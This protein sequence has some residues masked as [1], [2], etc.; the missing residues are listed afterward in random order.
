VKQAIAIVI[1]LSLFLQCTIQLGIVGY[2]TINKT[3]I[4]KN[5]CENRN[6]PKM[7]C[8]GK[9]YLKKQLKKVDE[10][11]PGKTLPNKIDKNEPFVCI[12][13]AQ[14]SFSNLNILSLSVNNPVNQ[15]LHGLKIPDSI[16]HP[17]SC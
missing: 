6:N 16:F 9:C 17:P 5:L 1:F 13:S 8:C 7:K 14:F 12:I 11:N 3:Y 15:N 10:N 4:A 2:Y